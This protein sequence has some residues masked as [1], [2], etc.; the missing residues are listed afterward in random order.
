MSFAQIRHEVGEP[1]EGGLTAALSY[2]RKNGR[3]RKI[4]KLFYGIPQKEEP[5][6][7]SH[8]LATLE[9]MQSY[10]R[11]LNVGRAEVCEGCD[12]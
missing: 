3:L 8:A 7:Y 10:A 9:A 6:R 4:D 12:K 11:K 5:K 1:Y 2:L